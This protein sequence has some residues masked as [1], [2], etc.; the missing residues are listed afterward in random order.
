MTTTLNLTRSRIIRNNVCLLPDGSEACCGKNLHQVLNLGTVLLDQI[1]K[2]K[3]R[4]SYPLELSKLEFLATCRHKELAHGFLHHALLPVATDCK[5]SCVGVANRE[6]FDCLCNRN[7]WLS[8]GSLDSF[9]HFSR[10]PEQT[11]RDPPIHLLQ[12][13]HVI[14]VLNSLMQLLI[15]IDTH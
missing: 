9:G 11:A 8:P 10:E 5:K 6:R 14:R 7:L 3:M 4:D 15:E 1:S 13:A 2:G 12:K